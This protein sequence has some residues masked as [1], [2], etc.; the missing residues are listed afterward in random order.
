MACLDHACRSCR[1]G[2]SSNRDDRCPRCGS[3]DVHTIGDEDDGE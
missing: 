1:H 3:A 2:W